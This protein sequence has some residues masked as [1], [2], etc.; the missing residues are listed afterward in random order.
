[1]QIPLLNLG[2]NS[3]RQLMPDITYKTASRSMGWD[4]GRKCCTSN[5][6][7]GSYDHKADINITIK[8]TDE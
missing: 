8:M 4:G 1:M 2:Y 7:I 3:S 5:Q 6:N